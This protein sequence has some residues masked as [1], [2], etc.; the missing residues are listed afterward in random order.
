MTSAAARSP[1]GAAAFL[2]LQLAGWS[3]YAVDR[4]LSD[5]GLHPAS[6]VFLCVACALTTVLLWPIYRALWR[7]THALPVIGA[8]V[9]VASCLAA[10]LWLLI[11]AM[12]FA[13]AEIGR[14]PEGPLSRYLAETLHYTLVHHKPFLFLSWSA[15]YFAIRY[16]DDAQRRE[17]DALTAAAAAREAELKM[18]RYQ[19]N[20]H[21]LFNSLNSAVALAKSAPDR[22]EQMLTQLS[23]FLRYALASATPP[24]I[25]LREELEAISTYLAIE[26]VRYEDKLVVRTDVAP[27]AGTFR[28]PS[29][30][31]LPLVEN[32]IKYG[33]ASSAPPLVLEI[34]ARVDDDAMLRLEVVHTGRW[35]DSDRADVK[36]G[37]GIGLENVQQRLTAAFGTRQRLEVYEEGGRVHAVIELAARSAHA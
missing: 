31:L 17:R 24:D 14:P 4:Y 8:V 36:R 23:D 2:L 28:V 19:L 34:S 9:I 15:I 29:F 18:L 10:F 20:P 6:V 3:A 37:I 27:E 21:F 13:A 1:R 11:S 5:R 35:Q 7:R 32:A 12:L 25:S 30:L 33:M 26:A 22:A 16:W